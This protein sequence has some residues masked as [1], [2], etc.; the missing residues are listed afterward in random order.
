MPI[1]LTSYPD[2]SFEIKTSSVE[3]TPYKSEGLDI[4]ANNFSVY[5]TGYKGNALSRPDFWFRKYRSDRATC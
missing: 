5:A 2:S 4:V 3:S 1:A